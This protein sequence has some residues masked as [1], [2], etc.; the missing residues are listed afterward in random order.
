MGRGTVGRGTVGRGTVG[1]GTVG[2]GTVG[3]AQWAG[4]IG[5]GT[6]DGAQWTGHSGRGTVDGH[7]KLTRQTDQSI[8][9]RAPLALTNQR[10]MPPAVWL[11]SSPYSPEEEEEEDRLNFLAFLL[12]VG[13]VSLLLLAPLIDL[14]D[15]AAGQPLHGVERPKEDPV[16]V[17][18][19]VAAAAA[20]LSG[21]LLSAGV[22]S[23]APLSASPEARATN[24]AL[25]LPSYE[26]SVCGAPVAGFATCHAIRLLS[27][28]QYWQPGPTWA[29]PHGQHHG[30]GAGPTPSAST[31]APPSSGYYPIDLERRIRA[32]AGGQ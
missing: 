15:S 23:G 30:E 12:T 24:G 26:S 21:G 22:A 17:R 28:S 16:A 27:P 14:Y 7:P 29:G 10:S 32:V 4:H 31:P 2:R 25:C 6:V 11:R 19:K 8:Q 5:R 1:R 3:G 9:A 13:S 18:W 20:L